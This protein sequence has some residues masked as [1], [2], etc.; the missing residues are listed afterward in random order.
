M[1]HSFTYL[2]WLTCQHFTAYNAPR[3]FIAI[4]YYWVNP[5]F[6][7][8]SW[9]F[10]FLVPFIGPTT[11]VRS[12]IQNHTQP[13]YIQ[14]RPNSEITVQN[15]VDC[16]GNLYFFRLKPS[17]SFNYL[18]T[19]KHLPSCNFKMSAQSK[20]GCAFSAIGHGWQPC[21]V[22]CYGTGRYFYMKQH[23]YVKPHINQDSCCQLLCTPSP[24]LLTWKSS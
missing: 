23:S 13:Q 17:L 16:P 14:T 10:Y 21:C 22:H 20:F 6:I 3:P 8:S 18:M 24:V 15:Y 7:K 11:S 2:E 1:S 12:T 5:N 4:N 19:G 9:Y